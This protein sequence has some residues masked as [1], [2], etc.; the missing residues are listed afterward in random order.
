MAMSQASS[1][2]EH[3]AMATLLIIGASRGIGLETVKSTPSLRAFARSARRT[4]IDHPK[5]EKLAG[6]ALEV[7]TVKHALS[8]V[9]LVIR[10]A[11][12]FGRTTTSVAAQS[13][14]P[15]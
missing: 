15:D 13:R 12:R 14:P 5:L 11:L 4:A 7:G 2:L 10:A 9:D 8:G 6:D 3:D 1:A